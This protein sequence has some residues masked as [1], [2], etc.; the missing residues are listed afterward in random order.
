MNFEA[1]SLQSFDHLE[2]LRPDRIDQHIN[3]MGLDEKRGMS[4]PGDANFAFADFRKLRR[5]VTAGALDEKGRN[6]NAGQKITFVPISSR[7]QPDTGGALRSGTIARR[8]AND[9]ASAS[10]WETNRHFRESI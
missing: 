4:D 5:R 9:I 1:W 6:K 3:F 2:P 7:P 8:L 10:F